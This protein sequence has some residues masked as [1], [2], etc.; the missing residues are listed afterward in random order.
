MLDSKNIQFIVLSAVATMGVLY[1]TGN[2]IFSANPAIVSRIRPVHVENLLRYIIT[3][4]YEP[5]NVIPKIPQIRQVIRTHRPE[6]SSLANQLE[7][8][9]ISREEYIIKLKLIAAQIASELNITIQSK[10]SW[11]VSNT[12]LGT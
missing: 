3:H 8:G 12:N 10:P 4:S 1:I 2:K 5:R 6:L 7:T 9:L 11:A